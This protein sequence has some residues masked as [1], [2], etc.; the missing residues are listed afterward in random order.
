MF[1]GI[2]VE[3]LSPSL[4]HS[5]HH[6]LLLVDFWLHFPHLSVLFHVFGVP[7]CTSVKYNSIALLLLSCHITFSSRIRLSRSFLS[8]NSALR[9]DIF[10]SDHLKSCYVL[11][12]EKQKNILLRLFDSSN[13]CCLAQLV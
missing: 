12:K 5:L 3:C 6:F 10:N 8:S 11:C 13:F 9:S 7:K 4:P 2:T 1:L